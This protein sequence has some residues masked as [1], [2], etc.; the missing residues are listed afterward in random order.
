[1]TKTGRSL[2]IIDSLHASTVDSKTM[3]HVAT[4]P[5][6]IYGTVLQYK[7]SF[8]LYVVLLKE[9]GLNIYFKKCT[10]LGVSCLFDISL[11]LQ[12]FQSNV[13][14]AAFA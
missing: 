7:G 3:R 9:N 11:F 14:N 8:I 2:C 6:R 5:Q 10:L 12:T 13:L 4:T 1:M